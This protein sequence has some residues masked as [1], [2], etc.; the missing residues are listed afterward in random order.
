MALVLDADNTSTLD[1][2]AM[3]VDAISTLDDPYIRDGNVTTTDELMP[4]VASSKGVEGCM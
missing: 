2:E 1:Q 3:T 4:L